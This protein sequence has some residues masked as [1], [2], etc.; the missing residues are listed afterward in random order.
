MKF[1][2]RSVPSSEKLPPVV[3]GNKCKDPQLDLVQRMR[4][5]R[6]ALNKRSISNP[7]SQSSGNPVEEDTERV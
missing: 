6:A 5:L 4:D 7:S 2:H 1:T 3:D